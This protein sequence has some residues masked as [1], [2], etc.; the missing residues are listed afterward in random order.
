MQQWQLAKFD[1]YDAASS[2]APLLDKL[3]T[4]CGKGVP[5]SRLLV[6]EVNYSETKLLRRRPCARFEDAGSGL[7]G[8]EFTK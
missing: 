7:A 5:R 3:D 4:F 8:H 2:I 6:G 1:K